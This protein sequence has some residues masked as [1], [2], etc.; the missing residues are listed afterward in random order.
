MACTGS[1]R[2]GECLEGSKGGSFVDDWR[3][4]WNPVMKGGNGGNAESSYTSEVSPK[5]EP[6][7]QA[8]LSLFKDILV[9]NFF[10]QNCDQVSSVECE[11]PL[12]MDFSVYVAPRLASSIDS[13][14]DAPPPVK[15]A[16]ERVRDDNWG[17]GWR[18]VWT[19]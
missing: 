17:F 19:K 2:Y 15:A 12:K 13:N 7:N 8:N 14:G 4:F 5:S 10:G 11:W 18:G 3:A 9:S 16:P 1:I 6:S